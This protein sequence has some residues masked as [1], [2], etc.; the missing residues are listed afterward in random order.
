MLK[1][2]NVSKPHLAELTI[3]ELSI[4]IPSHIKIFK[5]RNTN[6]KHHPALFEISFFTITRFL[7]EKKWKKFWFELITVIL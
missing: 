1:F 3:F 6:I 4:I 2:L 7:R 5:Q